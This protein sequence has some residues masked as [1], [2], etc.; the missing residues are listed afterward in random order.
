MLL[1]DSV[2]IGHDD[3][4][5]WDEADLVAAMDKIE[6][7]NYHQVVSPEYIFACIYIE[8]DVEIEIEIE[9]DIDIDL[10][11]YTYLHLHLYLY[12]DLNIYLSIY[13][14]R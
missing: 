2:K 4:R 8:I 11:I 13:L 3:G 5:M 6:L 10:S 1:H 7:V 14:Y 12:L 9:I